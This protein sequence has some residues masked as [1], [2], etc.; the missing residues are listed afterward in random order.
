MSYLAEQPKRKPLVEW[1]ATLKIE[2]RQELVQYAKQCRLSSR[3]IQSYLQDK[4]SVYYPVSDISV[5]IRASIPLSLEVEYLN[6]EAEQ[7]YGLNVEACQQLLAMKM[8]QLTNMALDAA[9]AEFRSEGLSASFAIKILRN[10]TQETNRCFSELSKFKRFNSEKDMELGGAQELVNL[11]T[12]V[13]KNTPVENSFS[14]AA[15]YAM[16][17][18]ETEINNSIH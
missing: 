6:Q 10:L 8:I 18:L 12:N 9:I 1:I 15:E 4:F 2:K 14:D 13:F 5:W 7:A 16:R 3:E 11:M 17:R